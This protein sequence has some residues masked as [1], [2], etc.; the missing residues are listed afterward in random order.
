MISYDNCA[1]S[2]K[3]CAIIILKKTSRVGGIFRVGQVTPIQQ[4][5]KIGLTEGPFRQVLLKSCYW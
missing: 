1:I 3:N 2:Y 4:Q 5:K